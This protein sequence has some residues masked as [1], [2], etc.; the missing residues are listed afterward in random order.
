MH[1]VETVTEL[2]APAD[3]LLWRHPSGKRR[4]FEISAGHERCRYVPQVTARDDI[5]IQDR[6][7]VLAADLFQDLGFIPRRRLAGLGREKLEGDLVAQ[8][9]I[10]D[11]IDVAV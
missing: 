11:V 3:G 4:I 1:P 2:L 8:V 9:L 6:Q 10:D 5:G 7:Q